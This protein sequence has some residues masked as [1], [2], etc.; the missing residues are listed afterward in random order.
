[1]VDAIQVPEPDSD[2][3]LQIK[4]LALSPE[5]ELTSF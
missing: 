1:M 4:H 2:V 5:M 3:I